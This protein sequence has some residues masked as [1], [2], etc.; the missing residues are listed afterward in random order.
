MG[1]MSLQTRREIVQSMLPQYRKASSV[2]KKSR[3][4]D[5]FAATTGYNRKYAMWLLNH[6]EEV[7]HTPQRPRAHH[8]GPEVQYALFLVWH[9]ANRICA[10]RLIPFRPTLVEATFATRIPPPYGRVPQATALHEREPQ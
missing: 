2:K 9:A 3:L 8:Y 6:T 4:L 7:Q 10:E 1:G 5:V